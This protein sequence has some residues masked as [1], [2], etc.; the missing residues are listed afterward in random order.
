MKEGQRGLFLTKETISERTPESTRKVLNERTEGI[1]RKGVMKSGFRCRRPRRWGDSKRRQGEGAWIEVPANE[2]G[3][4]ERPRPSN[5]TSAGI[6]GK[7]QEI[8]QGMRKKVCKREEP[9]N[10]ERG[11]TLLLEH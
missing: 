7:T 8:E 4:K 10:G 6:A 3:K 1:F 2:W 9:L 5:S 11:V